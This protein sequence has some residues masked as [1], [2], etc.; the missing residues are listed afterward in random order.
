MANPLANRE[1]LHHSAAGCHRLGVTFSDGA[2]CQCMTSVGA[3]ME[4]MGGPGNQEG[5]RGAFAKLY[6]RH[7]SRI[8]AYHY[9]REL[10]EG[11]GRRPKSLPL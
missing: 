8:Y 6:D 5:D 7:C 1:S 2:V 11:S 9:H 10:C 3:A 4:T